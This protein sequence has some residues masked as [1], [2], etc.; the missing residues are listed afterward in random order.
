MRGNGHLLISFASFHIRMIVLMK[1]M[2]MM[3]TYD[4]CADEDQ[5]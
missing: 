3:A 1:I 2:W 5:I 4:D